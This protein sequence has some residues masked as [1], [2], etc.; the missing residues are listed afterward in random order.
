MQVRSKKRRRQ[1]SP[2][3]R[4][5]LKLD[6]FNQLKSILFAFCVHKMSS[7]QDHFLFFVLLLFLT[8][9]ILLSCAAT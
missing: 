8:L 5:A 3:E 1:Q 7:F 6:T 9:T 4:R 2:M